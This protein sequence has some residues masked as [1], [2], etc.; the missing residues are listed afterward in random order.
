MNEKERN[1]VARLEYAIDSSGEIFI[2]MAIDDYSLATI[3]S[4]ASLLVNIPTVNFQLQTLEI[5]Q[6]AFIQ[7]NKNSELNILIAEILKRQKILDIEQEEMY[8]E[9][10]PM[11]KPTDLI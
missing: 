10:D 5:V 2:D 6:E 9:D 3:N 7:E 1:T 8:N 4:F 11:I